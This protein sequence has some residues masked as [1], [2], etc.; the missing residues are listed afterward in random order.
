MQKTDPKHKLQIGFLVFGTLVVI[1][2]I[3]YIVGTSLRTGAWPFLGILVL[4][5]AWPI[6]NY[7]MH[8][9]QLKRPSEDSTKREE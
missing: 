2:I 9:K 8:I 1:K 6:L 4:V 7:F 3:E 5:G